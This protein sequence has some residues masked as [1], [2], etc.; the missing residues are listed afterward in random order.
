MVINI[1][2][3]FYMAERINRLMQNAGKFHLKIVRS[4][5]TTTG[6]RKI[7]KALQLGAMEWKSL[8]GSL[9]M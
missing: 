9:N 6:I 1:A 8:E 2:D 4:D 5:L 3:I 7:Y